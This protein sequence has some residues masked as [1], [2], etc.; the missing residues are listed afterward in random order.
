MTTHR[1]R[2]RD[3]LVERVA[4]SYAGAVTARTRDRDGH[5][6]HDM[7]VS[8]VDDL[9]A[10]VRRLTFAA[11][12]L[13]RFERVGADEYFGLVMPRP[14]TPLVLPDPRRRD[15]RAALAEL[16]EAQRPDLRWYTIRAHRP[17]LGEIDVDVIT[18]GDSGPGSAWATRARVGDPAGFRSG[19]ALY[20]GDEVTGPQL[21]VADETA[22]PALLA[23]LEERARQRLE[24]ELR[25]H[26]EVPE[27]ATAEALG[28][29]DGV[30]VHV[31]GG[32]APG[33]AVVPRLVGVDGADTRGL[34]YAWLC[35]ESALVTGLRRHLVS[36]LGVE[37]RRVLFSGYWKLGAARP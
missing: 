4:R 2:V 29:P 10:G 6:Q 14:G 32:S 23:V 3:A 7:V 31:R 22:V 34:D 26:V 5:C 24:G 17:A 25:V 12:E 9:G 28:V 37:R 19:G 33:S 27:A 13:T 16:P 36:G 21:L 1:T 35:G 15:V 30:S 11:E 8:R 20:R 18:H